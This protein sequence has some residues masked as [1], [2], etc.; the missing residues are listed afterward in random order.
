MS[1]DP[2]HQRHDPRPLPPPP[3]PQVVYVQP[4]T[5]RAATVGIWVIVLWI[6]G[7][8]LLVVLCCL[9]CIGTGLIGG[10]TGVSTPSA[11]STP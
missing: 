9:G 11:T 4:Q 1:Y 3:P 8:L 2:Y 5:S 10:I 6:V 7:P